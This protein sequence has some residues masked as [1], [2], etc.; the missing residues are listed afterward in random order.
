M[1]GIQLPEK[2]FEALVPFHLEV[3]REPGARSFRLEDLGSNVFARVGVNG[4]R[5]DFPPRFREPIGELKDGPLGCAHLP[6]EPRPCPP[7][8]GPGL[9]GS[10]GMLPSRSGTCF[11]AASRIAPRRPHWRSPGGYLWL[12]GKVERCRDAAMGGSDTTG[13]VRRAASRR[14]SPGA[15][16][17]VRPGSRASTARPA[18]SRRPADRLSA[19][20]PR[21]D[22]RLGSS[23]LGTSV[24]ARAARRPARL[25]RCRPARLPR[26]RPA[27]PAAVSSARR[28]RGSHPPCPPRRG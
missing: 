27:P 21:R 25:P 12:V 15:A 3:E 20:A 9:H 2:P 24:M 7:L 16:R 4:G 1:R 17:L 5:L 26:C 28:G 22:R 18:A 23:T 8:V 14:R 6:A 19:Q 11:G 13:S 10:G